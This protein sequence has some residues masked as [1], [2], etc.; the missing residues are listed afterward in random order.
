MGT[1]FQALFVFLLGLILGS[2][3]TALVHRSPKG[4]SWVTKRSACP[5]CNTVLGVR[6][7]FPVLSWCLSK[8]KCRYCNCSVPIFYPLV[9]LLCAIL[10]LVVFL[11]CGAT[12]QSVFIYA[13]VPF[14]V[15]L[16]IVDFRYMILPNQLVFALF[17]IG[18]TR[19]IYLVTGVY[20]GV[21]DSLFVFLNYV[22]A[23][24][25]YGFIS[26][27]IGALVGMLKKQESLG[28][29]DVKFFGVA[30]LWLGIEAFPSF[31]IVSGLFALVTGIIWMYR[32]EKIFPFGPSLIVA[33]FVLLIH[34]NC[35][36]T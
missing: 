34:Q 22:G 20:D 5:Q 8:G 21:N 29:G 36:V 31:L 4:V 6:D 11:F 17:V 15:A 32:G 19:L 26:W 30:G 33:F 25:L 24:A 14:L 7:L 9:E 3:T 1:V 27:A 28:F 23:A 35:F 16:L 12:S 13:S 2:F 18:I 10:C